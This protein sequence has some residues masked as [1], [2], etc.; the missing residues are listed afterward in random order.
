VRGQGHRS[1]ATRAW[2]GAG[3][4]V[5]AWLAIDQPWTIRPLRSASTGPFDAGAYVASIWDRAR[6]E[7][8]NRAVDVNA[9]V[10]VSGD[11]APKVRA[12]SVAGTILAVDTSSRVGVVTVDA[13]PADGRA[14]AS[15]QIGPV[16]RGSALRDVLSFVQFTDVP[17]QIAFAAVAS[18]LNDRVLETV[19]SGLDVAS[20]TG[21]RV[22]VVGAAPVTA[23][24]DG[25]LPLIVPVLFEIE[26]T[27]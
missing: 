12:V 23:R 15:V 21:K 17:N 3:V 5:L 8:I 11:A 6:Q 13:A 4:F 24:G 19:L 26:V 9:A 25:A 18:E 1:R 22:M 7:V 16:I 14:D 27:R 20:L 10:P 2:I